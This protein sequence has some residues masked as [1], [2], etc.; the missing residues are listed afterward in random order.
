MEVT[1][2]ILSL[3]MSA[4]RKT[5]KFCKKLLIY[6]AASHVRVY[7]SNPEQITYDLKVCLAWFGRWMACLAIFTGSTG[8]II[9]ALTLTSFTVRLTLSWIR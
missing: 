3:K 4:T 8:R 2:L 7:Y 6:S 5:C 1:I 9:E